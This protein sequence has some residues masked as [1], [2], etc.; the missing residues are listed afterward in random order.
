MSNRGQSNRKNLSSITTKVETLADSLDL[1]ERLPE[2]ARGSQAKAAED[3]ALAISHLLHNL[4]KNLH[5]DG[6][7]LDTI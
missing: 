4:C 6:G 2:A 1:I 5:L 3:A 7:A